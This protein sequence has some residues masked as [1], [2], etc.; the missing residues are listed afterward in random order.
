MADPQRLLSI[1]SEAEE[2][3]RELLGSI[4]HLDPPA[5]AKG[6]AWA[7][8]SA[9]IAA[10]ALVS[11]THG[12]AAAAAAASGGAASPGAVASSGLAPLAMKLLGSKLAVGLAVAGT[13]LGAAA[14]YVQYGQPEPATVPRT[15]APLVVPP[16]T[17]AP[18]AI[19][20]EPAEPAPLPPVTV[21]EA[22]AKPSAVSS[23]K[24]RL[25]AESAL[26]TQA[27]AELRNGDAVAAERSLNRLRSSFPKGMLGQE[28]EVLAIEVLS[29]RGHGEA[30]RRRAKA[31]ISAY[32]KSPHSA[33]LS[34]FADAP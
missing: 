27:R 4:Q 6:E 17:V 10:V 12:S 34:R 25:S 1:G 15:A 3:E 23:Q 26:L 19:P 33:Q 18:L 20:T 22:P 30:A 7:R 8:L 14:V 9:Q 32:P 24:D 21:G 28:R 13:A 31:F 11:S 2:V 29:A 5:G 16:T